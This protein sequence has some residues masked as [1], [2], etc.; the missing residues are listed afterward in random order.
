MGKRGPKIGTGGRPRSGK[1]DEAITNY[2]AESRQRV[3]NIDE[4]LHI[5]SRSFVHIKNFPNTN[6]TKFSTFIRLSWDIVL[7]KFN[8]KKRLHYIEEI[9]LFISE[10]VYSL[11]KQQ[12]F[13]FNGEDWMDVTPSEIDK[14]HE[15]WVIVSNLFNQLKNPDVF[16]E[17]K[18]LT[19]AE[20][21]Y[22]P[23]PLDQKE[24]KM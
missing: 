4:F 22:F 15:E 12:R 2:K 8:S 3:R 23:L 16:G 6:K 9:M 14:I 13:F 10:T 1:V 7:D 19:S 20:G 5:L 24:V 11:T 17:F 21:L 18:P